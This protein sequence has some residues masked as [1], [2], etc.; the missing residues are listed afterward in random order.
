MCGEKENDW[1]LFWAS[2]SNLLFGHQFAQAK[3][4]NLHPI[5][6]KDKVENKIQEAYKTYPTWSKP[7]LRQPM[8]P[9]SV[10]LYH[11]QGHFSVEIYPVDKYNKCG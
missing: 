11:L 10:S 6:G 1:L 9:T 7:P 8:L 2:F 5:R 3:I 4:L